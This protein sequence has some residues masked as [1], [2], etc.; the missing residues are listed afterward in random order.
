VSIMWVLLSMR[1]SDIWLDQLPARFSH[2]TDGASQRVDTH[3]MS[4][5]LTR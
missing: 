2:R 4:G 3:R 1:E 5:D